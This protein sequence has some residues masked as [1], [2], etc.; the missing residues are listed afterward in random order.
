MEGFEDIKDLVM[1]YVR[2]VWRHRWIAIAISWPLL[3][4]GI[5]VVDQMKDRYKAETKVYIDTTSVLKPLLKGLAI[6]TDIQS[7]VQLMVRTLLSRPNLERS[8]RLMDMDI[9]VETD[10]DMEK[11]LGKVR[12]RVDISG[13]KRSNSYTIS[14]SDENPQK[15][16]RMVQTFLDIFVEDTLGK[17]VSESDSAIAFLDKQIEKYDK[18]LQ[19]AETRLETFKRKNVG[20]MPQDG[21]N[22]FSKY[23]RLTDDLAKAE[24]ELSESINRRDKLKSQL[25][26]ITMIDKEDQVTSVYDSKIKEQEVR[27]DDLLLSYTEEHPDVINT[28]RVLSSL[29]LR[30]KEEQEEI[31]NETSVSLDNPVFQQIQVLLSKSEANISSLKARVETY[32][33]SKQKLKKLVDVVPR[34]EAE[35]KRLNRDYVV[36]KENYTSLVSRREKAKISEDVETSSDQVKFRI[37]E[38]PH[39]PLKAS[40]P[41]RPLFD[42][43]VLVLALGCGYGIGLLISLAQ[44]VVY[45]A[46]ELKKITG[47][48][49]LGAINKFDTPEVLSQRRRN[50]FLF[51]ASN[52]SLLAV[53]FLFIILH[54]NEILITSNLKQLL[55]G[56]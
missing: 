42:L 5:M 53:T 19:D 29:L 27:L 31:S 24:L 25:D 21:A 51:V 36:H 14:Y 20:V 39:V 10:E 15:A 56:L 47:L 11:L 34:I 18:L 52:I 49:V 33:R 44:P 48:P 6:Q 55:L 26:S 2:G 45:S 32:R 22:Y 28:R 35:L 4:A 46:S 8:I 17:S 50:L 37:I 13:R 16:K 23:Q 3:I 38:P 12:D 40:F 54:R 30:K 43:L 1:Q 9:N 41:N 7:N